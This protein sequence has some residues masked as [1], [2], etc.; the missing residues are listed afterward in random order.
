MEAHVDE[1]AGNLSAPES[2][3]YTQTLPQAAECEGSC[4]APEAEE[5]AG[6]TCEEPAKRRRL[7]GG[8]DLGMGFDSAARLADWPR[9][10]IMRIFGSSR[11][12]SEW[13]SR[14]A[15]LRRRRLEANLQHGLALHTDFSG[16]GSVEQV[17]HLL[18]L[19]GKDRVVI[20]ATLARCLS[21][22]VQ[23]RQLG[24][25]VR[26]YCFHE[27]NSSSPVP[28]PSPRSR[29][30]PLNPAFRCKYGLCFK[31]IYL[32]FT[33]DA[34]LSEQVLRRTCKPN[35]SHSYVILPGLLGP[36]QP[37]FSGCCRKPASVYGVLI[38]A[39]QGTL[40]IEASCIVCNLCLWLMSNSQ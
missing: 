1:S 16:K 3:Q 11:H 17:L 21:G 31:Y 24:D 38:A 15:F 26:C 34:L 27:R 30:N 19:A 20:P 13:D 6:S 32:Q 33:T 8:L 39:V 40:L 25:W 18:D 36:R 7:I 9:E 37:A 22:V 29:P 28:G 12:S 4:K 35:N 10:L 14:Q 2:G 5:P 23:K